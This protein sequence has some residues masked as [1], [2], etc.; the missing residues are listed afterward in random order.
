MSQPLRSAILDARRGLRT[1]VT[2][3]RG[4]SYKQLVEAC[5]RQLA[6]GASTKDEQING[7]LFPATRIA[8]HMALR[9]KRITQKGLRQALE[10][11]EHEFDAVF[12]RVTRPPSKRSAA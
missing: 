7:R 8:L 3:S 2:Q 1:I 11:P 12:Q 6:R 9:E 10:A 4:C 5:V